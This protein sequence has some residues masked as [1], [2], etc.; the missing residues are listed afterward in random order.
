[1]LDTG[2]LSAATTSYPVPAMPVGQTLWAR[3]WTQVNGS[4]KYYEDVSFQVSISASRFTYP[5]QGNLVDTRRS[6]TWSTA[7]DAQ[8]YYL[9]VGTS[10]GSSNI[11][12]SGATQ[13]TSWPI[14]AEPIGDRIRAYLYGDKRTMEY[15]HGVS[16]TVAYSP[17][18]LSNP[19]PGQ[20]SPNEDTSR[21]VTWAPVSGASAYYLS[22]GTSPGADDVLDSGALPVSQTSVR[23]QRFRQA[24]S[25]G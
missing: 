12:D 14:P 23:F 21:P 3:L 20:D 13:N 10:P 7:P 6:F 17:A 5:T 9:W 8:A 19:V 22:I 24:D 2:S 25:Y 18:V 15:R 1:M 4:W 16:A 11:V